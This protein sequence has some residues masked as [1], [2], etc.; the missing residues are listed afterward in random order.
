MAPES[1]QRERAATARERGDTPHVAGER[2][3]PVAVTFGAREWS[4]AV[5]TERALLQAR[6]D[7]L[8]RTVEHKNRRL[9][10][11]VDRYEQVLDER[12]R[13]REAVAERAVGGVDIEFESETDSDRFARLRRWVGRVRDRLR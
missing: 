8:E 11:V 3:P 6:I 13:R 7:A 2:R 9:Q 4:R 10:E 12:E 5:C 1:T